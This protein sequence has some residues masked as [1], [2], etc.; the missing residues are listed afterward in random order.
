MFTL[1]DVEEYYNTAYVHY[2]KWWG[3]S[4]SHSLHYGIWGHGVSNFAESLV[5]TNKVLMELATI[6]DGDKILDAGCGVGGAAAFLA[7]KKNVTVEGITL[8]KKQL[9]HANALISKMGV[10]DRVRFHIMDFTQTSYADESFDVVWACESVCH[11]ADK[12]AF[13][14][15]AFRILKRGGRLIVSDF[16]I[17]EEQQLDPHQW[18][19]KWE[20][21]WGV[22]RFVSGHV[23]ES[24]IEQEGFVVKN[25]LDYTTAIHPSAIRLYRLALL[26]AIPS[27]LYNIT[28][29]TVTRFAKKHYQSGYFQYRALKAGLWK[30]R[31]ILGEKP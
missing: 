10:A 29:P 13:I 15:E 11:A 12:A 31:V 8:S 17:T 19:Q 1:K 28:H 24:Y 27:E 21:T 22:N 26:A 6:A 14:R 30:Y 16:F 20:N 25:N 9:D 7:S 5:N 4:Q 2:V 3:L 23:F 18:I